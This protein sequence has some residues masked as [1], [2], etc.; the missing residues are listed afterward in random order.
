ML[1]TTSSRAQQRPKI[2][3]AQTR[4][5]SHLLL[6]LVLLFIGLLYSNT[7]NSPPVLDDRATFID[8]PAVYID[9]LS[10]ASL[11]QVQAG[12]FGRTRF[13]PML[14]FA[15]DQRLGQGRIIQFHLTNILIH[16]LATLAVYLL[17]LGLTNTAVA[18]K[19]LVLL[20]PAQFSLVVA[21]FWALHPIQTN[22]VTY[23][24]QRMATLAT[25]FY[26]AALAGY[27]WARISPSSFARVT[28]WAA[29]VLFMGCGF[30]SKENSATLPLAALMTEMIFINPELG[31]RMLTG[32]R[33]YQWLV[34]TIVFLLVLPLAASKLT[35]ISSSY[36]LHGR[37][38]NLTERLFTELR[39]VVFYL[40]LLALPLPGRLNLDHDFPL[41]FSLLN[42]PATILSLFLLTFLFFAAIR[43]RQQHPLAAFGL[44]FFFLNLII[45]SSIIPL[46]LVFEHRLYLPSLGFII[47]VVSLLDWG[48]RFIPVADKKELKTIFFLLMMITISSLA[49][50]TSLRNHVWRD[51]LTLYQDIAFKSPLKPRAH[52]NLG[53]ELLKVDRQEEAL[54]VLLKA[55]A[56]GNGQS[57]EYITAANNIVTIFIAQEK[58][59][60]AVDWAKKLLRDRPQ[61]KLN[62]DSFPLLM[63]NLANSYWKLGRFSDSLE[64]FRIGIKTKHPQHTKLLLTGMETML[65]DA[66][67]TKDGRQQL[68]FDNAPASVYFKMA[69][70][71]L[72]DKDYRNA[73][74][75]LAKA[76]A[77]DPAHEKSLIIKKIIADETARNRRARVAI[78]RAKAAGSSYLPFK[79]AFYLADFIEERYRLLDPLVGPLLK[80]AVRLEPESL[81]AALRLA[82]WQLQ[83]GK[84]DEALKLAEGHLSANPD[85]PPL[86]EL[87][88]KCYFFQEKNE[89]AAN[90]LSR[91]L[92]VYPGH[93]DWIKYTKFIQNFQETT[94]PRN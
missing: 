89:K 63:A 60:E 65:L 18:K 64:A 67:T 76:L 35:A 57:E 3:L 78:N 13:I 8:N 77:I 4:N 21:A 80:K 54:A 24:V 82:R 16:I 27:I 88:A 91:L 28:G 42:P 15:V 84:V 49:I 20:T 52:T 39:V 69:A 17:V 44:L 71:L 81:N 1:Q 51:R 92:E 58:F 29:F 10:F 62:L 93:P 50:C 19:S 46:E 68:G 41:S 85:F 32:L 23:L 2:T 31:R 37:H 73:R 74:T 70:A 79:S 48:S 45:E 38:F 43:Y 12:R 22:G 26:F 30:L 6:L 25:L 61:E 40:S 86:L 59:Q 33:R 83:N 7:L 11:K 14:S 47:A 34:L 90:M 53:R 36:A 94:N 66:F 56:L 5:P 9:T 72:M 55:I 87:A 75:Y